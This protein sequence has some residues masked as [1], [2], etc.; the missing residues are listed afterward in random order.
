MYES[1]ETCAT[2]AQVCTRVN[3]TNSLTNLIGAYNRSDA[4]FPASGDEL[5]R[6][7]AALE[8]AAR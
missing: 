4:I 8:I 2:L 5:A 6:V 3:A 1:T 7:K